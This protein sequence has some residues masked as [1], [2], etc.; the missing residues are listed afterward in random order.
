MDYLN[1]L[2]L[3][4]IGTIIGG[5]YMSKSR[6]EKTIQDL[7]EK[8]GKLFTIPE[9]SR[10]SG[11][12][13]FTI[14]ATLKREDIRSISIRHYKTQRNITLLPEKEVMKIFAK[15]TSCL[16]MLKAL[17]KISE[18]RN[19]NM[20]ISDAIILLEKLVEEA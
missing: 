4:V 7:E 18:R 15:C 13:Q 1:F 2:D 16:K 12:D 5:D 11:V 17:N 9:V 8:E 19:G 10:I 3:D 6:Y 20:S 14:H